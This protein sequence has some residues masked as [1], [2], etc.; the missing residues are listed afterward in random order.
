MLLQLHRIFRRSTVYRFRGKRLGSA[1]ACIKSVIFNPLCMCEG[2]CS[3]FVSVCVS[4]TSFSFTE[5]LS[6][7]YRFQGKHLGSAHACTKSMIFISV[8]VH[9]PSEYPKATNFCMR[10]IY[11]SQAQ[12]TLICSYRIENFYRAPNITMHKVPE[13]KNKNCINLSRGPFSIIFS[14]A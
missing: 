4:V 2:Y 11:A 5:Y 12:V 3:H 7:V 8:C 10:L 1:H 6:T 9:T 14:H 13:R